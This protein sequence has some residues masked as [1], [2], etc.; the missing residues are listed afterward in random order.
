MMVAY[1]IP[2]MTSSSILAWLNRFARRIEFQDLP[3]SRRRKN[4]VILQYENVRSDQVEVVG[5][6]DLRSAVITARLRSVP[7]DFLEDH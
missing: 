5:A 1:R 6:T 4:R 7:Q 3:A 2:A